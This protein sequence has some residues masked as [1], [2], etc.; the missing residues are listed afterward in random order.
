VIVTHDPALAA[1]TDRVL[2][3]VDGRIANGVV[4]Q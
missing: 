1:R 2:T 3:L 4:V